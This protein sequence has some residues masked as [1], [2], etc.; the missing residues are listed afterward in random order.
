VKESD[1]QIQ[2]T[3]IQD[4]QAQFAEYLAQR[5]VALHRFHRYVSL[6]EAA[7]VGLIV[8]LFVKALTVSIY[9]QGING[10]EI[11]TWWILFAISGLPLAL[12]RGVETILLQAVCPQVVRGSSLGAKK[13]QLVTGVQAVFTGLFMIV[14]ALAWAGVGLTMNYAIL[15]FD[16]DLIMHV[17]N[18]IV[19]V[20][21]IGALIQAAGTTLRKA[22]RTL[23]AG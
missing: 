16:M 10:L 6:L 18:L 15:T 19:F 13:G 12:W 11:A 3:E 1:I 4:I 23:K 20:T 21:V 5:P 14:V 7:A 8:A 17:V 22:S 2:N 9:W